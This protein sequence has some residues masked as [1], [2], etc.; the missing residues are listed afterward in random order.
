MSSSVLFLSWESPWPPHS[1]ATLRTYGLLKEISREFPVELVILS[2]RGLSAEQQD[3][4]VRCAQRITVVPLPDLR[5]IDKVRLLVYML[6]HKK[7]YHCALLDFALR[8]H[9]AAYRP[10]RQF[11]G[12]VYASFGHWGTMVTDG[13]APNW[14]LDQHNADV[15]FWH[16]Y[17]SQVSNPLIKLAALLNWRLAHSHFPLIYNRINHVVSVCEEDKILTQAI[18]PKLNVEVIENG[19][20]SSHFAPNRDENRTYQRILFT[21]TSAAR[22]MTALHQFVRDVLPLIQ[23]DIPRI[24]LLV[25]GNFSR[26]AQAEFASYPSI[27]FTGWVEDMRPLYNRSDVYIAPFQKTHGSKLKIAEAMAMGMPI[28]STP[29]GVRGFPLVNG[30]SVA[31]AESNEQFARHVIDLLRDPSRREQMGRLARETALETIDWRVLGK[32]LRS[33]IGR[34]QNNLSA[35]A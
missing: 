29:A 31:I 20:D 18:Q 22:N 24:E 33:I 26:D 30:L 4:L 28:V 17:A 32:R 23:R 5:S 11:S 8:R 27:R 3:V 6:R 35:D 13:P 19:I 9:P 16:A 15:H 12:I 2:R 21:G 25:G 14:I 7:P 34:V 10:I 1:G